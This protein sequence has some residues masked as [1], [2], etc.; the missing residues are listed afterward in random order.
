[1]GGKYGLRVGGYT[2]GAK[3]ISPRISRYDLLKYLCK[4]KVW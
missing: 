3:D 1:M 4:R 2:L